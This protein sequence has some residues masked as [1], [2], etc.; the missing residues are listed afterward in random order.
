MH[1]YAHSI[2]TIRA[3]KHTSSNEQQSISNN[4]KTE[5]ERWQLCATAENV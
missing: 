3:R 4:F 1:E 2:V 5:L